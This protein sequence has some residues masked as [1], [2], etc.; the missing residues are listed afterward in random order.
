MG[1]EDE[2]HSGSL[3]ARAKSLWRDLL[4]RRQIDRELDQDIWMHLD[5]LIEQK[6]GE[7]MNLPEAR[8]AA[9]IELGGVEHV[10]EEVRSV[11]VGAWVR[12]LFQD[13]ASAFACFAG[14]PASRP[15]LSSPSPSASARH[16][17]FQRR[18]IGAF[19][20]FPSP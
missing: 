3:L 7:G 13:H 14:I 19:A 1:Q 20:A 16:R 11:R 18:A 12:T 2:V 9:Q 6:I 8:R 10:K 15:S 4:D 5:L 17:H